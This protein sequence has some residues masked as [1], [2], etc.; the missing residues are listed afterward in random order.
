MQFCVIKNKIFFLKMA[1][2]TLPNRE[3]V[4]SI[5]YLLIMTKVCTQIISV[6]LKNLSFSWKRIL[7]Y[8]GFFFLTSIEQLCVSYDVLLQITAFV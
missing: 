7:N 5:F 1:Q 8:P 6:A 3:A 2:C 4:S